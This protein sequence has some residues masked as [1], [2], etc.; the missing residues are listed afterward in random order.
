MTNNALAR[1][2]TILEQERAALLKGELDQL[3]GLFREK[4]QV[5]TS[6]KTEKNSKDDAYVHSLQQKMLRNQTLLESAIQ[7]IRTV[8]D[9][10]LE[11]RKVRDSL[12]TYDGNGH[13]ME[14]V[15]GR[16]SKLEKRA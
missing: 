1:L 16:P 14:V 13:R 7:G 9:R 11:I 15:V 3:Q 8:K 2:E 12:E 6:L 4:E 5:L 10:V